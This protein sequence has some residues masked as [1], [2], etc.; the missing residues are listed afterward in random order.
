VHFPAGKLLERFAKPESARAK[1]KFRHQ[2]ESIRNART[3]LKIGEHILFEI[4]SWRNLKH[5]QAIFV[6]FKHGAFRDE[7]SPLPSC[8]STP[9]VVG[10][11]FDCS[12][13]A[14]MPVVV[15]TF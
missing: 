9:S 15:Q 6:R 2:P 7:Q 3:N 14:S 12:D 1:D 11:L 13:E 10:A 4:D 5:D 8:E